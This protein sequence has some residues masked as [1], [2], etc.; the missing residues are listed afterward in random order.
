MDILL[1]FNLEIHVNNAPVLISLEQ[2]VVIS[3]RCAS[4]SSSLHF[5][6]R[7][8]IPHK[9]ARF[10]IPVPLSTSLQDGRCYHVSLCI[11]N[12]LNLWPSSFVRTVTC[13]P[14]MDHCVCMSH[15]QLLEVIIVIYSDLCVDEPFTV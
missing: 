4:L 10:L 6:V 5:F 15:G 14:I 8:E 7:R 13:Y 3:S 1:H 9:T 2:V 12:E 11:E